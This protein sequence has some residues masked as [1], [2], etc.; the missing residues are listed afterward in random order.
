MYVYLA[1]ILG[2]FVVSGFI[3]LMSSAVQSTQEAINPALNSTSWMDTDH[4][5]AFDL[6]ANFV[7]YFWVYGLIVLLVFGLMYWGWVY[8]QRQP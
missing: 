3:F 7:T 2:L 4:F 1:I 8:V 5:T 6:A